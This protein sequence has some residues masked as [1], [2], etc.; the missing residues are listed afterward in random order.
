MC[1]ISRTLSNAGN[2]F[3]IELDSFFS[4]L[5]IS[6]GK[7]GLSTAADLRRYARS[8]MPSA[9]LSTGRIRIIPEMI[10]RGGERRIGGS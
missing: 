7:I 8:A 10:R 1:A 4:L 5:K 3:G 2:E 6:K 9:F